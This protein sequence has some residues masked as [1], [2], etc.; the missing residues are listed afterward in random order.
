MPQKHP[1]V[2][3]MRWLRLAPDSTHERPT[4]RCSFSFVKYAID[5]CNS[6]SFHGFKYITEEKRHWIER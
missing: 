5:F 4:K 2:T 1:E 3:L 6:T